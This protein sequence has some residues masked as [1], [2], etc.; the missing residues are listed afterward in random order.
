[1]SYLGTPAVAAPDSSIGI[2]I[3][4]QDASG[5]WD[6]L[7]FTMTTY[8]GGFLSNPV[9]FLLALVWIV[10]GNLTDGLDRLIFSLF[11]VLAIP[12]TFG[13]IEFQTRVLYNMPFHLL[14][15]LVLYGTKTE[16]YRRLIIIAVA[17]TLAVYGLHSMADLYLI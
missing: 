2:N 16:S 11:F 6:R 13:S 14:P 10:K 5:R 8:V 4:P 9:L 1:S 17:L 12:V 3:M 7:F 15:L